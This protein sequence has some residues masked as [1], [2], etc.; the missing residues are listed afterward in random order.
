MVSQEPSPKLSL[1]MARF[2]WAKVSKNPRG[3]PGKKSTLAL[4]TIQRGEWATA[5]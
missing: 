3:N 5:K 1:A 2:F 4:P